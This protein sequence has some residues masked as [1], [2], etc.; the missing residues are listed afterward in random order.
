MKKV[1]LKGKTQKG[2]NR[3]R[4]HGHVWTILKI[5]QD[6]QF[7]RERGIWLQ[8]EPVETG[9]RGI[10]WVRSNDDKDFELTIKN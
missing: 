1:I 3:I 6:P 8:L 10:R 5:L 2:K 4:E 9:D 7:V